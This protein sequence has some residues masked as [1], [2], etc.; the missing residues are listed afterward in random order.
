MNYEKEYDFSLNR[1]QTQGVAREKLITRTY[2]NLTGAVLAFAAIEAMIFA[3]FGVQSIVQFVNVN[4][5]LVSIVL[6]GLC[7]GGPTLIGLIAGKNPSRPTQYFVLAFHVLIYAAM[8]LPL[9]AFAMIMTGDASLIWKACGLTASL[10]IALTA[11]VFYTRKDFSFLR[12]LLVFSGI[13]ALIMILGSV[14]FGFG[15]GVWFSV[16]MIFLACG[17]VLYDTSNVLLRYG[18]NDDVL[19]AVALFGAI[20]TLFYYVLRILMELNRR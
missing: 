17:Y 4:A 12:G 15:L 13:A 7:L 8:F 2:L 20:M 19:A 16:L 1:V 14:I 18:E 5:K 3:T 10:F 11:A 9:L 6:L